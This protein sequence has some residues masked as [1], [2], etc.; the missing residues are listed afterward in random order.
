MFFGYKLSEVDNPFY[1]HLLRWNNSNHIK[2]HFSSEVKSTLGD[3]SPLSLLSAKLPSGFDSW[4]P[5]ARSQWLESTIF[6]SGYLLSSQGDRMGMAN[7][8]EGRYPFLDHRVIEFCAGLPGEIKLNGLNEKFL[9]K[10]LMKGKIPESI[11]KRPKQPYR[12]PINS[13]FMSARAPEYIKEMISK[14]YTG[15]VGIFNIDSLQPLY[16]KLEKTG[17]ASEMD[18]MVLAAVLSTHLLHRQFVEN[19]HEEFHAPA[20]K[21]P[22]IIEDFI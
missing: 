14:E 3:Y 20:L 5:L 7:S 10:K 19:R 13:V 22:K 21:N 16:D 11:I 9:L 2:K 17:A 4:D 8:V 15:Q 12:A 6:M 18:N 1:S